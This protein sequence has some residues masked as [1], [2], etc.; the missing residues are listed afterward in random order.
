MFGC[1]ILSAQLPNIND[2]TMVKINSYELGIGLKCVLVEYNNIDGFIQFNELSKI[3]KNKI[4]CS[5]LINKIIPALVIYKDNTYIDLSLK[6]IQ[7]EDKEKYNKKFKKNKIIYGIFDYISKKYNK[8]INEYYEK[9]LYNIEKKFGSIH[10]GFINTLNYNDIFNDIDI[11]EK[12]DIINAINNRFKNKEYKIRC[13]IKLQCLITGIDNIIKILSAGEIE[14]IKITYICAP[15][16]K[17]AINSNNKE[18]AF[19]LINKSIT[20][21]QNESKKYNDAEFDIIETPYIVNKK[22]SDDE[23][24]FNNDDENDEDDDDNDDE[25]DDNNDEND[26]NND[27]EEVDSKIINKINKFIDNDDEREQSKNN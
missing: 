8:Q 17:I 14:N 2:I 10:N 21:I 23:S 11:N 12:K 3:T 16:Y 19:E 25:N 13:E 9:Y 15:N 27:D 20:S 26:D 22:N 1:K 5:Q 18:L 6:Q 7:N 4:G 24:D